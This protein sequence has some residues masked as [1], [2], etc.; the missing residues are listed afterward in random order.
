VHNVAV[1]AKD[2]FG[3]MGNSETIYFTVEVP[4]PFPTIPVAVAS[5][6]AVIVVGVGLLVYFK[7]RKR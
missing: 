3:N 6:A 4:E 1:Y 2:E 7:K 5:I